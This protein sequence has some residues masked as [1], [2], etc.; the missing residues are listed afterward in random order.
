M[1]TQKERKSLVFK[2]YP[3]LKPGISTFNFLKS[4]PFDLQGL[5]EIIEYASETG[6]QYVEVRDFQADLTVDQCKELASVAERNQIDL[7]YVFNKNPLDSGFSEVF[8]RALANV[9]VLPGPGILRALVSR[10][11]FDA[12]KLKK[13]WNSEE[14]ARL[15]DITEHCSLIAR[16]RNI[17]FVVENNNESFFGDGLK[18]FGFADFFE[19]SR[20][21]GLQMDIAN[22]FCNSS[23]AENDPE[24]V[25]SFLSGMGD[26]WIET[27]LKTV[28]N[29]EPQSVLTDN[30]LKVEKIVE[31]MGRMDVIYVTLELVSTENK[32]ECFDN[33]ALSIKFLK[34]KGVL[35]N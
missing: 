15:V 21:T 17:R 24:R 13:G 16:E 19:K 8:D 4:I 35:K 26:R 25:F 11:E 32:D 28:K 3:K 7:I 30:P 2:D 10:T 22:P 6:F 20:H 27:H 29:G 12:D 18:Y 23:R 34:E 1:S 31:M 5:A 33:H 14:L 9:M